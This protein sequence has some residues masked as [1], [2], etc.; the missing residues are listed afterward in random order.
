MVS[1]GVQPEN[2]Y[3][4]AP[5]EVDANGKPSLVPSIMT[6]QDR[7]QLLDKNPV[8]FPHSTSDNSIGQTSSLGDIHSVSEFN[9]NRRKTGLKEDMV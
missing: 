3:M 5:L 2:I 9:Q 6:M 8:P 4:N 7:I 1:Q